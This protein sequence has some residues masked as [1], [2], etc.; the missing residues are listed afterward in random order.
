[1]DISMKMIEKLNFKNTNKY[2]V[3]GN[4]INRIQNAL[5]KTK[6]FSQIR[7]TKDENVKTVEF[8]CEDILRKEIENFT[9]AFTISE[10]EILKTEIKLYTENTEINTY[11]LKAYV[12]NLYCEILTDE[13]NETLEKYTIRTY[14]RIFNSSPITGE[15]HINNGYKVLIKPFTWTSKMEPCTEQIIMYDTEVMAVNIDH[16][17]SIAYNNT[18]DINSC[19]SLLLDVGFELINS[20]YRMFVLNTNDGL[21]L[22]RYRTGFVDYEL[23]LV[24]KDNLN[25]LKNIHDEDDM[26]SFFSGKVSM[27]MIKDEDNWDLSDYTSFDITKKEALEKVFKSHKIIKDKNNKASYRETI[28][29]RVHLPNEEIKIPRCIR[30]YFKSIRTME[31]THKDSFLASVRM[32]NMALTAGKY[33]PTLAASYKICAVEALALFKKMAFSQFIRE[34]ANSEYNKELM[35]YYYGSIRSGHFH[36]GKFSFNEYNTS[37]VIETDTIFK[38]LRD[39]FYQFNNIIRSSMVSYIESNL[40]ST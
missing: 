2:K 32:Y 20:E 9:I 35:D 28:K 16:A 22:K 15:Y 14:S 34:Y 27:S 5:L 25:G 24:V 40:V 13:H 31:S 23:E 39:D 10:N 21:A 38:Q 33:E 18:C 36:S 7:D 8:Y 1:M 17:R 3:K 19:L 30:N 12:N 29:P 11:D 37:L 26:N 4:L 6:S